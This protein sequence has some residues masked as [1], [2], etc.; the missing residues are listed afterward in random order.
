[1]SKTAARLLQ[2]LLGTATILVLHAGPASAAPM[3][4]DVDALAN[5]STGGVGVSMLALTLGD[6]FTV[7]VSP[8]DLWNA[9]PLPRWSNA[10]GLTG[11]LFA[12]GTD[13][14]GELLGTQIGQAFPLWT[15]NGFTAPY[16]ALVGRIGTSYL[17]LGTSFA[18]PAPATGTLELFY[19]DSNNSDNTEKISD[20]RHAY[21]QHG[22]AGALVARAPRLGARR[23]RLPRPSSSLNRVSTGI[24]GAAQ[25]VPG[26]L[27]PKSSA[28]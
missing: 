5:S 18:G 6:Q 17:L 24:T 11:N 13:E 9:G 28:R 21:E 26:S 10:N 14:S 25:A 1:M 19:W 22:R 15:Q 27:R 2:G 12:T 16:G 4:V 20:H 23:A 7:V 3:V 8:L